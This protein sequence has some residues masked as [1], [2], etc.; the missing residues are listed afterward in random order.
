VR[1]CHR[2]RSGFRLTEEGQQVLEATQTLFRSL[3]EF[4]NSVAYSSG[5]L[6]ARLY[7][8]VI[9][10]SVFNTDFRLHQAIQL[11]KEREPRSEVVLTVVA[12]SE[13]EQMVLD[14]S[15]DVGIGFFPARRQGLEYEA[16][17]TARMDLYCGR[18]S[19][20]FENAPNKVTLNKVLAEQHAARGYISNAQLPAF[21][22]KLLVGAS[23]ATVEGLVTLTLSGK[24]TA[25]LPYHYAHH[26]TVQDEIRPILPDVIGYTCLYH[27]V[28]Q[29]GKR[30]SELLSFLVDTLRSIHVPIESASFAIGT[31]FPGDDVNP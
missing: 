19:P 25:Y 26:W 3:D 13:V 22:R 16:L 4:R 9:D 14:G 1:L 21:E 27:M 15:C 17:Y 6:A 12:A 7:I 28:V 11:L 24:Y 23:S 31:F 30:S 8:S 10:N 5:K 29:K 18:G 2:G 20:L